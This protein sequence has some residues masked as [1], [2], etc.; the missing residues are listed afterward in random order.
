MDEQPGLRA[1]KKAETRSALG[2]A[3]LAIALERGLD[4]VSIDD[5]AA[6]ANVSPRTFHNY[7]ESKADALVAGWRAILGVYVDQV[8]ARPAEE[9]ILRSLEH[10]LSAIAMDAA[11]HREETEA[12]LALL[13][14]RGL[15]RHRGL[16][17]EEAARALVDVVAERTG[18]DP[19]H[20]VYPRLVTMAAIAA[21]V[22]AYEPSPPAVPDREDAARRI[23]ECF[24]LLR[25][26][27]GSPLPRVKEH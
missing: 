18:T 21:V 23:A 2:G 7:F 22:S 3:A 5:I 16:L 20:D 15:A 9:P 17:I 13:A 27:L 10:V 12:H 19:V 1:R 14:S 8:R 26:G 6:A 24:A 25:S 4:D 11:A